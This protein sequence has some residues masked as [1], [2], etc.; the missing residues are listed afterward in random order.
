M[1]QRAYSK[2][3]YDRFNPVSIA[4][5]QTRATDI[6][7]GTFQVEMK[8]EGYNGGSCASFFWYHASVSVS[9]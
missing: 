1:R 3:D 7:H 6:L 9:F 2:L 4:G 5:I 8:L